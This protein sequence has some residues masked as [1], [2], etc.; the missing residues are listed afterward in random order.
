MTKV[1]FT[2]AESIVVQ[3]IVGDLDDATRAQ[4]LCDYAILFG[5]V[6]AVRVEDDMIVWIG[7]SY[8]AS[9]GAFS[10]PP[11]AEPDPVIE[12]IVNVDAPVE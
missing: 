11:I 4:F 1:A 7:G 12:E 5:A 8:D 6:D 3:S 9:S 2:N 10:P